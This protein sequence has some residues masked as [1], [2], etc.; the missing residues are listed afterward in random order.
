MSAILAEGDRVRLLRV[1]GVLE[2]HNTVLL[3]KEPF[4]VDRVIDM[5]GFQDV[6]LVGLPYMFTNYDLEKLP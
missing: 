3:T 5:D 6:E 2:D 1:I 4:V